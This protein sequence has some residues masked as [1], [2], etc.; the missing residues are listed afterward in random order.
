MSWN[1][2][3]GRGKYLKGPEKPGKMIEFFPISS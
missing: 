3:G 1:V 2:V